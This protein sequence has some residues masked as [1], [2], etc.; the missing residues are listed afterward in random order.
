MT[1]LRKV[2]FI[3]KGDN[4]SRHIKEYKSLYPTEFIIKEI[5]NFIWE[6]DRISDS[7]TDEL[8]AEIRAEHGNNVDIVS[9]FPKTWKRSGSNG[10]KTN[11][12]SNGYHINVTKKSRLWWWGTAEHE[13]LHG[14]DEIIKEH[15]GIRLELIFKV[16]DFDEDI[17]HRRT[18]R[19][20]YNFDDVWK[21]IAPLL[22]VALTARRKVGQIEEPKEVE[23]VVADIYTPKNFSI[24]ELVSPALLASVGERV[25][26]QMFD[27]RLLRNL[28]WLRE[29]FGV[30]YVNVN[31]VFEH[32]GFDEGGYRK[33]GTSQHNHGRAID[34]HFRDYTIQQVHDILKVEYKNMPEPNI[35][36]E[37]T[38]NGKPITWLH[39][40]VRY[41]DK[42]GIYFFNA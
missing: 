21:T 7:F 39:M 14:V 23:T 24:R 33:S 3:E 31:G 8:T 19:F 37:A 22:N 4:I 10:Y 1:P 34:C 40:D 28:Q 6:G 42:K 36:V 13:D 27:E 32:R 18:S 29:R 25:A 41:S 17:V 11:R 12:I 30:T 2:C 38:H 5:E 9:F 26:W 16:N 35:W 15:A 20:N